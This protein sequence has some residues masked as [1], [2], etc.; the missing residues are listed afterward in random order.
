MTKR[1]RTVAVDRPTQHDPPLASSPDRNGTVG[2]DDLS[3]LLIP[4]G[5]CAS[6]ESD[7]DGSVGFSDLTEILL[8]W[9]PC[10]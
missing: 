1:P 10:L 2:F 5:T 6:C 7:N 9:G 4:W 8:A 3:M